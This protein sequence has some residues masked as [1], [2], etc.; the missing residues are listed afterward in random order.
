[1]SGG[2]RRVPNPAVLER[3]TSRSREVLQVRAFALRD[4]INS[5]LE[6]SKVGRGVR[7]VRSD[8]RVHPASAPGDPPARE[9][10]RLINSIQ[11]NRVNGELWEVGPAAASFTGRPE[12]PVF[13]EFGTR[14]MQPRPFMRPGVA[15][16]KTRVR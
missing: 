14:R 9:T 7:Y 5:V 11:S 3:L 12:Y 2:V 16:F 4:T 6:R 13:L 1:M 10:G 15:E 8:G